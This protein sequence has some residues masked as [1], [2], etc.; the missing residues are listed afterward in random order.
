[1]S[2]WAKKLHKS[3]AAE[4]AIKAK[5]A[6]ILFLPPC[7]PD[8]NPLCWA[9]RA[10]AK[11]LRQM[12]GDLCGET[13]D[14]SGRRGFVLTLSSREQH[15]RRDKVTSNICTSSRLASLAFSA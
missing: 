9:L 15:I 5:G 7:S 12:P 13:V 8:L 1:L 11:Y 10:Q 6:W 14:A 4:K 3:K 2:D